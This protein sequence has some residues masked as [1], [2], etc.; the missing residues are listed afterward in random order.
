MT[1]N[2]TWQRGITLILFSVLCGFSV[3]RAVSE[4][5]LSPDSSSYITAAQNLIRTGHVFVYT[6]Y[7]SESMEPSTEPYTEQPVGF[8]LYL[9]FFLFVLK[10]PFVAAAVAQALSI[11]MLYGAV[12]ALTRDFRV[13]PGFQLVCGLAVTLFRPLTFV[14]TYLWSETLFTALTLWVIHFLLTA[15]VRRKPRIALLLALGLA[16]AAT[17]TRSIGILTLGIF[18]VAVWHQP[19]FLHSKKSSLAWIGLSFLF[20]LGPLAAWSLRN[21]ILYGS[22]SRTHIVQNRIHFTTLLQP[23]NYLLDMAGSI[24]FTRLLIVGFSL[25][26]MISPFLVPGRSG[27]GDWRLKTDFTKIRFN[28]L[29]LGLFGIALIAAGLTADQFGFGGPPGI[30]LKQSVI[31]Y[32]GIL[33]LLAAWLGNTNILERVRAWKTH[34]DWS[35]WQSQFGY[36]YLLLLVGG[37]CHLLGI[38][39]LSQVTPFSTLEDRLLVPSLALLLLAMLMGLYQLAGWGRKPRFA[40]AVYAVA[41]VLA[42]GSPAVV[43]GSMIF[44][45]GFHFPPEQQLWQELSTFPGINRVSHFYTDTNFTHQIYARRPQ[46]VI[47]FIDSLNQGG[48]LD[49]LMSKGTCP[50]VLVNAGDPMSELMSQVYQGSGL[51]RYVLMDGRFELYARDCLFSP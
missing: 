29:L 36:G 1:S 31:I 35:W 26:C 2:R 37:L 9:V 48:Y 47:S 18:V 32:L 24:P 27:I 20:T 14:Y 49:S 15:R 16:A 22:I 41:L 30:G 38:I 5:K 28:T 39:V 46:R 17:A 4:L 8:P 3:I 19:A 13:E 40:M 11:G 7:P 33:S 6:N 42:V 23:S 10:Q 25:L 51:T 45:P 12:W 50:F 43:K 44:Q 21:Q 34:Y